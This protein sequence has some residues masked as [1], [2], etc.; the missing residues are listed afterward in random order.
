MIVHPRYRVSYEVCWL[1]AIA[2]VFSSMASAQ[3]TQPPTPAPAPVTPPPAIGD[4]WSGLLKDAIPQT[5]VDPTLSVPQVSS[6]R[7]AADNFLNH[8]YF[9][10]RTEYRRENTYFTGLP[11]V[12]GVINAPFTAVANPTGIPDQS[13]FQP[14]SNGIYSFIDFGTTGWGSDR[15][16]SHFALRYQQDLSHVDPGSPEQSIL[17]AFGSNR[18]FEVLSANIDIHGKP[19]D[20]WFAGDTLT[21]GRQYIY[22]A[23][24][25]QIDGAAFKINRHKYSV[26]LYAGRRFTYY[27]DPS[28]RVIGG[29]NFQYRFNPNI[30]VEYDVLAYI[31]ATHRF[32]YRQR[33]TPKLA[34]NA[35]YRMVGG[36]A[37]DATA[38][39]VW[40]PGAG[41]STL[42]LGYWEKL[43]DKDYI[44][45]FTENARDL[46]TA[47]PMFALNLGPLSPFSQFIVDARKSFFGQHL[48][49]GGAVIVRR[50]LNSADQGPFN[51]SFEDYRGDA[52]IFP[53]RKIEF[54]LG[55]H[56][57]D[58]DR[59]SP[60]PSTD[61][62]DVS[63]AGET[64]VQDFTLQLGRTFA[65]GRLSLKAG[66]F[67]RRINYQDHFYIENNLHERG[68]LAD[69]SFKLDARTR[70]YMNWDLDSSFFLFTPNIKDS[71]VFRVG[72][73]WKY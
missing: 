63:T 72:M 50:L 46:S 61:F 28:Q 59:L 52:Q 8:F 25:A 27:S 29:A 35:G 23:E 66:G 47:N 12:T 51:T 42:R 26:E 15:I 44:F 1:I 54:D 58:S 24:P 67:Y 45:D 33:I 9:D 11:T 20:G 62:F 34:F 68:L 31:R 37:T 49:L 21:L 57:R 38:N 64:R 3:P 73:A 70:L 10:E 32:T 65:E 4:A 2:L 6:D 53:L 7:G 71:Q 22:G 40:T 55:F 39:L 69:V 14:N 17:Q 43:S 56:Q 60:V 36:N 19:T 13:V 41:S 48:R 18:L 30:S 5:T 16:D